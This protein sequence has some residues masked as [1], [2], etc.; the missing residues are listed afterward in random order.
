MTVDEALLAATRGG[1]EAL[2]RDDIG[3]IAVGTRADLV[4]LDALSYEHLVYRPG[5]PLI[6]A[7]IANGVAEWLDPDFAAQ[8]SD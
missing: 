5:V 3:R 7:T 4:I 8:V 6:A 2:Q 1:A